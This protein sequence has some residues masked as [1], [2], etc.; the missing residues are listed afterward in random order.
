M[1]DV[2]SSN[3][4][5]GQGNMI[6]GS[7]IE[8]GTGDM[9]SADMDVY[10]VD[11]NYIDEYKMKVIAG[12]TFS[13]DFSTDSLHS[14]II[15][16]SAARLLGYRFPVEAVGRKFK[17]WGREGNIIGV[18][19]D[20]HFTSLQEPIKPL[21][22]LIVDAGVDPVLSIKVSPVNLQSTLK[23]IEGKWNAVIPSR[24]F[25]YSFLDEDFDK[26]YR[27]ENRFGTLF[28]I[29]A[30]LAI[31]ISA[32]GLLGLSAYSTVQRTKEI[33]IRKILGASV[34]GIVNALSIDFLRLVLIA[35]V[36]A[37]PLSYW[38]M[39]EWLQGF[40]YRINI[41]VW[42]F[43]SVGTIAML[44]SLF[45]ISFQTIKAAIANPVESLRA[46]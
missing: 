37:F 15:N 32:L 20:F 23:A 7:K 14:M 45:T 33:G 44:I 21:T 42:I 24:I 35:C 11:Y 22:M 41:S 19:K 10:L 31:L 29:F 39:Y 27:S 1:L 2:T 9:Q 25:S 36:I 3:G 34:A 28:L 16:E 30:V 43:V 6:T 46:E 18:I 13:K 17:Q 26:Q 4:I 12:R 40:A 8:N 38:M 5:P